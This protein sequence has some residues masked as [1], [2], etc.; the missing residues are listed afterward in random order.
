MQDGE[1]SLHM[2]L[3]MGNGVGKEFVVQTIIVY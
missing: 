3:S 1:I 2:I